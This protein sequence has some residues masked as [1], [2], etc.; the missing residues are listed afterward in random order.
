[1]RS[2]KM[3]FG[4]VA[5]TLVSSVTY[6]LVCY[7]QELWRPY[8]IFVLGAV[9]LYCLFFVA[10]LVALLDSRNWRSFTTFITVLAAFTFTIFFMWNVSS[11]GSF[12]KY[13]YGGEVLVQDGA[14]TAHGYFR[15]FVDSLITA[16]IASLGGLV[17][18]LSALRTSQTPEKDGAA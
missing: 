10:P 8:F 3:L 13:I 12:T 14:I 7:P 4:L 16:L 17:L 9:S 11:Y 5:M 18:W 6:T 15:S 2:L 1:M